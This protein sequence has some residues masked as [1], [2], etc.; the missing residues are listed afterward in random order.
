MLNIVRPY[1]NIDFSLTT[2]I[3]LLFLSLSS[4]IQA[5]SPNNIGIC[6]SEQENELSI[7]VNNYRV[8]NGLQPVPVSY[9]MS[10]VGQWHVWDLMTNNPVGGVCNMHS[11]SNAMPTLWQG[12]CYTPDHAQASQMWNKPRQIS[13]N[14][15]NGNGYENAAVSGGTMNA[16]TALWVWQNSVPHNDVILNRGVWAGITFRA[17]GVGIYGNYAVLWFGD[18]MS[19]PAGTMI[20]CA[21]DDLF[22]NG[23]E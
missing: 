20:L 19:D 14:V 4:M 9:W 22:S 6:L 7:L 12:M 3:F 17:M 16:S 10:T 5:Q 1:F 11:W 15:F 8:Q 23:F 13:Q 21:S 2:L 18:T